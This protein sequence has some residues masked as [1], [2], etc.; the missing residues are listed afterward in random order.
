MCRF[1]EVSTQSTAVGAKELV[2]ILEMLENVEMVIVDGAKTR[3]LRETDAIVHR[4]TGN[5][6]ESQERPPARR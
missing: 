3:H 2:P 4:L 1:H 5:R 6:K